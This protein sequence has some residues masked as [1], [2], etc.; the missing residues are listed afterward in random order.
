LS[1]ILFDPYVNKEDFIEIYNA[2]N[3]KLSLKSINIRNRNNGQL[4]TIVNDILIEAKSYLAFSKS[5]QSLAD[6]YKASPQ[7]IIDNDL[8]AF[9]NDAGYVS[10][11]L[12]DG[13]ILDEFEYSDKWHLF[14]D[15]E[16]TSKEGVSLEKIK[17][18]PFSN[19]RYNWHSSNKNFLYAT[20]GYINS[21]QNDNI[22]PIVK[23]FRVLNDKQI[24]ICYNDI[25]DN[26]TI[27]NSNNYVYNEKSEK[28]ID[29]EYEEDNPSKVIL[30][31]LST[32]PTDK[33]FKLDISNVKDKN[34]NTIEPTSL[35]VYYGLAPKSGDLVISEIL[36]NPTSP[37]DDFVEVYNASQNGIQ[38]NGLR[39]KNNISKNEEIITTDYVLLPGKYVAITETVQSIRDQYAVPD[40]ARVVE[41][42]LPS[43]NIDKGNVMLIH[44]SIVLDSFSYDESLHNAL[45]D[46]ENRKGVSL[47]KILLQPFQNTKSNW[48]SSAKRNNYASPG[49]KNSNFISNFIEDEKIFLTKKSF[50]PNGDGSDDLLI[51]QYKLDSPGFIANVGV[52]SME[53][54]LVK[55]IAK[56]E[57]LGQEGI[58]TWDGTNN[59][60]RLERLGVYIIKGIIFDTAGNTITVKKDCVLVDFID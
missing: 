43:F 29:I 55:N 56:N 27:L 58:L 23:S 48:Q 4:K 52:Y 15:E 45:I 54:F 57:L 10:I 26:A 41:N 17:L 2:S 6:V 7:N 20:P 38:L 44:E 25:M 31:F 16:K 53:G 12:L 13:T 9:N 46:A 36:F 5:S 40:T 28:P 22:K 34:Q 14:P 30:T 8:P 51:L 37:S 18:L 47:E 33:F 11:E 3:K 1:E 59:D 60:G 50:S 21:N 32:F 39:I 35:V 49:Y 42:E 24:L 19:E